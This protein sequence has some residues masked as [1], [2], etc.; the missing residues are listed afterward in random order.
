MFKQLTAEARCVLLRSV[1]AILH[2]CPELGQNALCWRK[3]SWV[4]MAKDAAESVVNSS[5]GSSPTYDM[6]LNEHPASF[7]RMVDKM[8]HNFLNVIQF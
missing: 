2:L 6:S 3:C 7:E 8:L 5:P 4:E 1:A